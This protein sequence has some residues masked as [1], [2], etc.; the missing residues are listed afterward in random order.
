MAPLPQDRLSVEEP[1]SIVGVDYTGELK[2]KMTYH[3]TKIVP[4]YLAIFTCLT[5]RAVH[6]EVVLSNGTQDFIMAFKRMESTKG[7]PK[8]VYSDNALQFKRAN[9]EIVETVLKNNEKI[10]NLA[11]K[12]KFKW[13]FAVEYGAGSGVWERQV[14][15]IKQPLS[16][17][18]GDALITYTELM[19]ILKRNRSACE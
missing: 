4:A 15:S 3:S 2:I 17:V 9:K 10:V 12:Y 11:D 14:K 1:F 16:K 13:Y 18:L 5:T 8:K 7:L 19:T 6:L